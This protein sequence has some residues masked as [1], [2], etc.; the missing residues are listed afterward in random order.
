VLCF[1]PKTGFFALVLPNLN[2]SDKILHTTIVVRNT[3][4]G[5]LRPRS[6]RGRLQAKPKRL[7]FCN[8]CNA[9]KSYIQTTN[10]RDFGGKTSEWMRGQVLSWKIPEFCSVG[11]VRS[12]NS[13]FRVFMVPFD[14]PAH[15][16]RETVLPKQ[17]VP[18]ESRDSEG[19][20]FASTESLWPGIWEIWVPE[21]AEKWSRDHHKNWKCAYRHT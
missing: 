20:P 7:C 6:A 2:R 12:Q 19:V 4:V 14:Y 3:L 8:T 11:G 10:R 15:S 13:I 21:G 9:R 5:R 1:Y 16:L 18:M 17:A